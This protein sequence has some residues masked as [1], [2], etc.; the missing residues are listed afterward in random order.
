MR[1]ASF[2]KDIWKLLFGTAGEQWGLG[3]ER[4]KLTYGQR[5]AGFRAFTRI[6][7][8]VF[9]LPVPWLLLSLPA[10]HV[11]SVY[12]TSLSTL[13]TAP[14]KTQSSLH[15]HFWSFCTNCTSGETLFARSWHTSSIRG[16]FK[17]KKKVSNAHHVRI[18]TLKGKRNTLAQWIQ[19][20]ITTFL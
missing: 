1:K 15:L 19:I 9:S 14:R 2:Y 3:G 6:Y 7:R 12:S 10:Q 4:G 16:S 11:S 18:Q 5:S 13:L 8:L 20:R 17:K